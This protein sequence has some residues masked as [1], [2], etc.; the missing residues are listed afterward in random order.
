MRHV[1]DLKGWGY[2]QLKAQEA[3]WHVGHETRKARETLRLE[4]LETRK[5]VLC[6]T[7]KARAT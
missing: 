6:K 7:R 4:V 3:R 1:K 5:R 2:I